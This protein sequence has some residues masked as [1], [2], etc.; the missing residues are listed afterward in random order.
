MIKKLSK[1]V[2]EY[3]TAAILTPIFV[4]LEV[5]LECLIPFIIAWLVNA[6]DVGEGE[7]IKMSTVIMYGCIL[8]GMA[9]LSLVFG[10]LSGAFCAKASS[11]FA[12][13]LRKDMFYKIQTF[14]FE[15]IDKFS[16]PSLVTRL[17]TDSNNVQMSFMMIIRIAVRCPLMMVFSLVM[18]FV[19]G[20]SLG[21][22]FVAVIPP[23]SLVLFLIMK[24]A[25][26]LF[27]RVFK[28][29]DNLNESI[30]ENVRG[31]RV[32]KSYVREDYEKQKFDRAATDVQNDFTIAER[33]LAWSNPVMQ[34]SFYAVLS[35]IL[36]IGSYYILKTNGTVVNVGEVSQLIV[37]GMQILMSLI[38]FSMVFAMI[39]MSVESARRVCEVLD[40]EST[41]R[42]PE[43]AVTEVRD[44]SVDFDGVSFKYALEAERNVL[45][46]ID[47]HIKSGETI[48]IIGGTGSSKT[49]LVNLISRLYDTTE[50][51]V[52]V[53]GLNV[54]DYDLTALRNQVAVVLQK[55]ELF[56]GTIKENLRWGNENATDEELIEACKLAQ[57]DEFIQG[58]PNGYDTY[59]EQGGANVSGGQKQRLC[60]ARALLKKPK[61]LILDDSTSA[62]DTR[63]DAL[64]RKAFRE[65]IPETTKIIIAQRTSSVEDADYIVIMDGGKVNAIGTHKE[66]LGSN[67]IYTEVY[68]T[69]NKKGAD[70]E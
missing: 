60:I 15:S 62:V 58:F 10:T 23:L 69:Q 46:N 70:N 38:M 40:E 12:K 39:T 24:K 27:H 54:K 52:K 29:Y 16:T 61:I 31:M 14:S 44:G 59:I 26:P 9:V 47:L 22:I 67:E 64:I 1:S 17:T 49:S 55:N 33:I 57:A 51:V 42:S 7:T 20:G 30:Q 65:Y 50:G 34:F 28:K 66:L 56:S 8:I 45:E 32:V 21:W 4:S 53:G 3:K 48:G 63:T 2:R 13:N 37:Y 19:M 18:T 68:N 25:M 11:G 43:N 5:V 35:S 36:F 41:L 6:I